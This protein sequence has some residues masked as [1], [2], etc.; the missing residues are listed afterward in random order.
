MSRPHLLDECNK[1][2]KFPWFLLM[3][4]SQQNFVL[5]KRKRKRKRLQHKLGES[6]DFNFYKLV[7]LV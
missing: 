5:K 2:F 1:N 4:Q 6:H 7:E 3:I